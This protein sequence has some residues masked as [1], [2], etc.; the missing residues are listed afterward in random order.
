MTVQE[1]LDQAKAELVAE[2]AKLDA[3]AK[4][5]EPWLAHEFEAFKAAAKAFGAR[6]GL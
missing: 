3:E 4:S 1:A 6:F 2:L 5:L